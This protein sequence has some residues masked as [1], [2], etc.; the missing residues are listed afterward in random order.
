MTSAPIQPRRLVFHGRDHVPI[1]GDF[2]APSQHGDAG[3]PALVAV[4]G[5]GWKLGTADFYRHWGSYLA[6]NGIAMLAI[7]YRLVESS[8]HLHPTGLDDVC[9]ALDFLSTNAAG[10]GVDAQRIGL[11][12]DSAGAHLAALAALSKSEQ[13]A[14]GHHGVPVRVMVGVYGVYDMLAQWEHDQLAR[15]EDQ[16]TEA[17][18]GVSPLV[19]KMRFYQASPLTYTTTRARGTAFLISWGMEDDTVD[20]NQSRRFVTA[21]KQ[22]GCFVR[23]LPVPGAPHFW[24]SEP[25]SDPHGY[26]AR[27]AP[28]L[29]RFLDE[30]L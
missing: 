4:H 10:L 14:P 21:L 11:M 3:A 22:A 30:R 17:V 7:N 16:I 28:V 27:L 15:P 23:T 18:L 20:C 26:A 8:K 12:G 25:L 24:I 2:Y 9:S 6:E 19:D 13:G 5:G 29:L 1:T